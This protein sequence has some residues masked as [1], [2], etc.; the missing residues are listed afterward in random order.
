MRALM[1]SKDG[2]E[3]PSDVQL[4]GYAREALAAGMRNLRGGSL[5]VPAYICDT[6]VDVLPPLGFTVRFLP[7]QR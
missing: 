3:A 1:A 2:G 7:C 4:F 5:L 6:A